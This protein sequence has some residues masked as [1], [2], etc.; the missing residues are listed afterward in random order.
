MIR[1]ANHWYSAAAAAE[2]ARDDVRQAKG[3]AEERAEEE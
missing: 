3:N 2:L 1:L